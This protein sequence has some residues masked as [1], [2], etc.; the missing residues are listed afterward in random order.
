MIAGVGSSFITVV[1]DGAGRQGFVALHFRAL[2]LSQICTY[3]CTRQMKDP[4]VYD[5][6]SNHGIL[7]VKLRIGIRGCIYG[8]STTGPIVFI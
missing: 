7:Y 2:A 3:I 6:A 8:G 1:S 4:H 5:I